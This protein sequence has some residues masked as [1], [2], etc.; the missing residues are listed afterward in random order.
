MDTHTDPPSQLIRDPLEGL[1]VRALLFCL[2]GK[3]RPDGTYDLLAVTTRL[4]CPAEISRFRLH[5][6]AYAA[7]ERNDDRK[8]HRY[9]F[10]FLEPPSRAIGASAWDDLGMA[11]T[12]VFMSPFAV[13]LD[14]K[15]IRYHLLLEIDDQLAAVAPLDIYPVEGGAPHGTESPT[16]H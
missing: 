7:I 6:H 12:L 9:R 8:P 14:A 4:E 1:Y 15:P 16:A 13:D 11:Q 2:Q 3:M 5:G 10:V